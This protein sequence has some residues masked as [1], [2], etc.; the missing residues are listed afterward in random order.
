MT[1]SETKITGGGKERTQQA[2]E[3]LSVA[4]STDPVITY[5][6]N[7]LPASK[8]LSY[9]RSLFDTLLTAGGL[10]GATFNEADGWQS[11]AVL[12]HPGQR[13]DNPFTLVQS[14]LFSVLWN[15]GVKG[16]VRML[17]EYTSLTDAAKYKALHNRKRFYY[18]FFVGTLHEYRGKGLSSALIRDIQAQAAR[19]QLP[20]WLEATTSYSHQLYQKLGFDTVGE[21][22]LGKGKAAP[23]GTEAEGGDGVKIWGMIWWPQKESTAESNN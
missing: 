12:M 23:D 15:L 17:F 4:F 3:L 19:D 5:L 1:E 7:M 14:G 9:R 10:N 11:C 16:C 21:I 8:Q 6:L 18:V 2:A 20:V 13:V 22:V